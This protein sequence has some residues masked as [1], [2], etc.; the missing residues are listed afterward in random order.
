MLTNDK[1][2]LKSVQKIERNYGPVVL[3]DEPSKETPPTELTH[4][5]YRLNGSNYEYGELINTLSEVTSKLERADEEKTDEENCIR[6]QRS[7]NVGLLND[8]H[9]Q[10]DI[11]EDQNHL[12]EYHVRK[13]LKLI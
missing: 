12:L 3:N 11:F 4:I 6:K 7:L 5:S 2:K 13:L 8:I 9:T 10:I 1:A